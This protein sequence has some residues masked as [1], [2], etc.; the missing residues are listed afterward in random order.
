M[1]A[2]RIPVGPSGQVISWATV[3]LD[4]YERVIAHRWYLTSR[5][6][7]TASVGKNKSIFLHGFVVGRLGETDGLHVDHI[8]RD[9]LD[10]RR[11][12]LRVVTVSENVR[13][14]VMGDRMSALVPRARAMRSDGL[15]ITEI[16]TALNMS[17]ATVCKCC[18]GIPRPPHPSFV[19]SKERI[20]EAFCS[21]YTEYGRVP[22]QKDLQGTNGMPWFTVVYR[23]FNG[24]V[25]ARAF[26]G[27][28]AI[29]LRSTPKVV[30]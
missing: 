9:R 19:W 28:G 27:L 17:N 12:N 24:L 2:I 13:N 8:N 4:D 7:A 10:N 18:R 6:Y 5:G 1:E 21:F 14:S 26:A 25:E 22:E 29:D 11:A 3:D 15:M 23:R 30:A 20:A 16:A